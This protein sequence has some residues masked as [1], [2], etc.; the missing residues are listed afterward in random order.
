LENSWKT[1]GKLL[2]GILDLPFISLDK[3][4]MNV[5]YPYDATRFL[6]G[7]KLNRGLGS[8]LLA[9]AISYFAL[10]GASADA[11]F[12]ASVVTDV[13]QVDG[14]ERVGGV[15]ATSS[16]AVGLP[17]T[18][19][20]G[21][22]PVERDVS[23][24]S[25]STGSPFSSS[26]SPIM[27]GA[28]ES[29]SDAY[30]N[31]GGNGQDPPAPSVG[32]MDGYGPYSGEGVNPEGVFG[33]MADGVSEDDLN[34]PTVSSSVTPR[35]RFIPIVVGGGF[36]DSNIYLSH[37]GA[38]AS[39]VY[40]AG[41]GFKFQ[42]GDYRRRD[43]SFIDASYV[44]NGVFYGNAPAANGYCQTA[45]LKAQ[46]S[47]TKLKIILISYL[48]TGRSASVDVGGLVNGIYLNNILRFIFPVSGKTDLDAQLGQNSTTSG[49]S[50][51]LTA[52]P[53]LYSFA[54]SYYEE[55][56]VG[57]LTKIDPKF[58]A[59]MQA[60]AGI[61][62]TASS[63]DQTYETINVRAEYIPTQKLSLT[64]SLGCQVNQYSSGGLSPWV[65]PVF[66]LNAYYSPW[67][68][69]HM[70]FSLYR[71][72][73]NSI[74]MSGMNYA[75]TGAQ[76]TLSQVIKGRWTPGVSVGYMNNT[77]VPTMAGVPSGRRDN[78]GYVRPYVS[79]HFMKVWDATAFF[80]LQGNQSSWSQYGW[81]ATTGGIEL[82]ASF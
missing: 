60:V 2:G 48:T 47:M 71:N 59:G 25:L 29:L 15:G 32:V 1:L 23:D 57:F 35:M 41:G 33:P 81:S 8:I 65:T 52:G 44:G 62:T 19:A 82:K 11:Q 10:A 42:W 40:Y 49:K 73:Q 68:N 12:S 78:Y 13:T 3:P 64:G 31:G 26:L 18:T 46:Y 76:F 67:Q 9:T 38:V 7:Y 69:T 72:V 22:L 39:P 37:A 75:S 5:V 80:Q 74:S 79:Y 30:G 53:N 6:K 14:V 58:R 56:R 21:S 27:Q 43:R 54:N 36:Y 17:N 77:Y 51:I 63:P 24:P 45:L 70:D 55:L 34:D 16:E 20:D 28:A 61:N 4:L 66:A 50:A